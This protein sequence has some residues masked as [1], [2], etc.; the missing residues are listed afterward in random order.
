MP[1]VTDLLTNEDDRLMMQAASAPQ[2]LGR[3]LL[4]P[5]DVP[6]DRVA[7]MRK[8]LADTFGDPQFQADAEKI[9]L[10]VNAPQTGEQL[11]NV[12]GDAYRRRRAWSSGC[13]KLNNPKKCD[14]R[15]DDA[16]STTIPTRK[17]PRHPL[18]RRNA[19]PRAKR[20]CRCCRSARRKAEAL[21]RCPDETIR[22]Y[23]AND[24]LRI[25]KPARYGGFEHDYDVLCEV[26][27][28]ARARL[29]LA[30]LGA[31]GVRRQH[32]SSSPPTPRRRRRR[33]GAR[34]RPR[35]CRTA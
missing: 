15:S 11:Q 12:I 6:A 7:A 18:A 16:A 1:F 31:H 22:D 28:D 33:S 27:P 30:G 23:L 8:A 3:P 26:E 34:T 25:C 24:L 14:R 21:R 20:W 5:P 9:G 13:A 4:L 19:A 2:A 29:R 17:R 35:S 32:R 10:I